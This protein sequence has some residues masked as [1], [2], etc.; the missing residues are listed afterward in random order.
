MTNKGL[1]YKDID[2][3]NTWVTAQCIERIKSYNILNFLSN[4]Q[5]YYVIYKDKYIYI[6]NVS[7]YL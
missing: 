6:D 2:L 5:L 7:V 3:N 4:T 1:N